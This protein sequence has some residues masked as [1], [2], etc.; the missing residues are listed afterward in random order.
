MKIFIMIVACFLVK[1]SAA[2]QYQADFSLP[3]GTKI[4]VDTY[5][6]KTKTFSVFSV[7]FPCEGYVY[8]KTEAL[9]AAVS[10]ISLDHI[11]NNA[12]SFSGKE[13]ETTAE[14]RTIADEEVLKNHESQSEA[15]V[16]D[17]LC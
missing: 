1:A 5:D 3:M 8:V 6:E 9:A 16:L 4:V 15:S 13:F 7:R 14:L 2:A 17:K 10:G 11:H 12:K